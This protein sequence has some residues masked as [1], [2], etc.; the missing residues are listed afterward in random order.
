MHRMMRTILLALVATAVVG[1]GP[2]SRTYDLSVENRTDRTVTLWLMKDGPPDEEGWR[3]PEQLAKRSR[4]E[5]IN[6]D[7]AS[8]P[9]G[10]TAYT[11]ELKGKFNSGT[12]AIMRVYEGS[13]ALAT[14]LSGEDKD[15]DRVDHILTPGKS[16][17]AVIDRDGKLA[18]LK[19]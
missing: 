6:Y 19:E 14:L 16:K 12:N 4:T 3:S 5:K 7:M 18:V 9:P 13:P 11:G 15:R 8:V 1:C 2:Q 17:L 10:K